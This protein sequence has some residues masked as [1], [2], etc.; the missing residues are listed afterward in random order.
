[1][2]QV[3][4]HFKETIDYEKNYTLKELHSML[5]TSYKKFIKTKGA[6]K[7]SET[8][9]LPSPYNLFIKDTIAKMKQ[10]KIEGIDPKDFMKIAAKKW[11]ENK[12]KVE[13]SDA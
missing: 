5:E 13:T 4:D 7:T 10:E 9:K 8:K 6:S 2:E 3:I 12:L 11:Q 1:M